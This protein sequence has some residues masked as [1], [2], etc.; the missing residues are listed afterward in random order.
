MKAK[1]GKGKMV[2]D[3]GRTYD[4]M[5]KNGLFHGSGTLLTK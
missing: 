1:D 5:W 2:W 4:G 3:D